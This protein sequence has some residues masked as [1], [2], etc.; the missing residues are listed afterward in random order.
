MKK[1]WK[2]V[3]VMALAGAAFGV[4]QALGLDVSFEDVAEFVGGAL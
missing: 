2:V 1:R 4:A 3:L